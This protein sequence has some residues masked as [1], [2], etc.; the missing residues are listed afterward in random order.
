M[1]Q[2]ISIAI[3]PESDIGRME[4]GVRVPHRVGGAPPRF[5][6]I[7][8]CPKDLPATLQQVERAVDDR[9]A[10]PRRRKPDVRHRTPAVPCLDHNAIVAF[11]YNAHRSTARCVV[12][13]AELAKA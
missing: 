1:L 7:Q 6:T 10:L 3:G 8:V 13:W 2:T 12:P 5:R 9:L 4:F 11:K